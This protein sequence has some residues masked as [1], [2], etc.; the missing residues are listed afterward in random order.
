MFNNLGTRFC[1]SDYDIPNYVYC[2]CYK[3][4]TLIKQG[5]QPLY[6]SPW[7]YDFSESSIFFAVFFCFCVGVVVVFVTWY[8]VLNILFTI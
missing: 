4:I 8:V 2:G 1:T 7:L 5:R 3:S 6:P